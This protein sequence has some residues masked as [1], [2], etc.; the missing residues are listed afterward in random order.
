MEHL[1]GTFFSIN[2]QLKSAVEG[3]R[4]SNSSSQVD[5]AR[6]REDI[7]G[8]NLFESRSR[9]R[10]LGDS[11]QYDS[12]SSS[13]GELSDRSSVASSI[14]KTSRTC[15][16]Q[17]LPPLLENRHGRCGL[18]GL[19]RLLIDRNGATKRDWSKCFLNYRV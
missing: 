9:P 3:L 4:R 14:N 17:K 19:K 18:A 2:N 6:E 8:D 12:S 15:T 7:S 5:R 11:R 16:H 13:D 10:R 1:E